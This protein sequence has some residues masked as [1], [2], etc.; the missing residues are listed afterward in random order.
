M[1][2]PK[3]AHVSCSYGGDTQRYM[4]QRVQNRVRCYSVVHTYL[5][6]FIA[7]PG[8]LHCVEQSREG[9]VESV[10]SMVKTN[11]TETAMHSS[12]P[13]WRS[14]KSLH[15]L[16]VVASRIFWVSSS[17]GSW[18]LSEW[19]SLVLSHQVEQNAV[20]L[21]WMESIIHCSADVTNGQPK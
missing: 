5:H 6:S 15:L 4:R 11:E 3:G 19:V 2:G 1:A 17:L 18:V 16:S 10:E 8:V 12:A 20:L 9:A 21:S 13:S 14:R 7:V